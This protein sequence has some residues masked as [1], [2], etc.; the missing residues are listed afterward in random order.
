MFL[1]GFVI[2]QLIWF[3]WRPIC[4]AWLI[5]VSLRILRT[6]VIMMH[7]N[8]MITL[9]AFFESN[10]SKFCMPPKL[11]RYNS[12]LDLGLPLLI[13]LFNQMNLETKYKLLL[14]KHN[15]SPR[16]TLVIVPSTCSLLQLV[17]WANYYNLASNNN[18]RLCN[19]P[20]RGNCDSRMVMF[21]LLKN[22]FGLKDVN[23]IIYNQAS[24][25]FKVKQK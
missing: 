10:N 12:I 17:V 11:L 22:M 19:T 16:S 15:S 14:N 20:L 3:T 8:F 4:G 21:H 24:L 1:Y 2:L 23:Y 5:T 25:W 9:S 18:K 13:I 7:N 6:F